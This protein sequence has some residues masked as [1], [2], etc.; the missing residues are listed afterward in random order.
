MLG[1]LAWVV[2]V[3]NE[4]TP[5][6]EQ[7]TT[8]VFAKLE[9][10]LAEA[11]SDKTRILSATIHLANLGDKAAFDKAWN[12]W[13]GDDPQNWPQRSCM[14]AELVAGLLVEIKLVAARTPV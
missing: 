7:Q 2:A 3:D 1:D 14:G 12:I 6:I 8:R 9:Q 10:F 4:K 13:V 5:G 11:G